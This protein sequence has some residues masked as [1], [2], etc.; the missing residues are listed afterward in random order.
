[1]ASSMLELAAFTEYLANL[2]I[3]EKSR[4]P[5]CAK[6]LEARL[7]GLAAIACGHTF[8]AAARAGR[9]PAKAI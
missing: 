2:G 4:A 3:A 7:A 6:L 8:A 9:R 1:M 5:L